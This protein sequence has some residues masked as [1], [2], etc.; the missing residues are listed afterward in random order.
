MDGKL[1]NDKIDT[2][3]RVNSGIEFDAFGGKPVPYIGWYW[4]LVDFDN[5]DRRF[6]VMP[7]SENL[8]NIPLVGFMENNKWGYRSVRA[9]EEQWKEI[10][11]LLEIA[12]D[13]PSDGNLKAVNDAIQSLKEAGNDYQIGCW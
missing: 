6:G 10:R 2:I 9:T 1:L 12:A 13:E 3:C 7:A 4:R 5:F 11:R 8:D